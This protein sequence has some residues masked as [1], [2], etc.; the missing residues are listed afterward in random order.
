[1]PN[2]SPKNLV[3]VIVPLCNALPHLPACIQSMM[4][5]TYSSWE[6]ILVDDGSTD[7]SGELCDSYASR[8]PR[9]LVI[10]QEN[11]GVSAA[12]NRGIRAASGSYICF[13]D[14]DDF[15]DTAM[16][17]DMVAAME[18]TDADC[19]A[20]G[21]TYDFAETGD[22]RPY[23]VLE[24][25][26]KLPLSAEEY[27][28]LSEGRMLN[29]HCGKLFRKEILDNYAIRMD[30]SVSILEDGIFVLDYLS[31]AKSLYCLPTASYHY[32][33]TTA[34]SL[35]KRYHPDALAAWV[36]YAHK[37][38]AFTEH[39]DAENTASVY[40]MLW[41]RFRGFLTDVY[42]ASGLPAKEKHRLLQA[43]AAAAHEVGIFRGISASPD[44]GIKGKL[45]FSL[46]KGS[47]SLSLHLLLLLRHIPKP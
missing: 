39:M 13:M 21:L 28:E 47:R 41:R 5:Q 38:I 23:T 32:R 4:D 40:T 31:H 12:R 9:I 20:G 30:E 16:L 11:R 36:Q 43:F 25:L 18:K 1:M 34:P 24:G 19:I 7:G 33:Q 44:R 3:S 45:L 46:V 15:I 10:H 27:R 29:S 22:S 14:S 35:Q 8:D 17:A 6:L 42:A 2:V 26:R 37:H